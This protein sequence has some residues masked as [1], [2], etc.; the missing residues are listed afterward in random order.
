MYL[1]SRNLGGF[2]RPGG[3][4]DSSTSVAVD[5]EALSAMSFSSS[6][7]ATVNIRV[8]NTISQEACPVFV[9]VGLEVCA[10]TEGGLRTVLLL[11]GAGD[12]RGLD[13]R[14]GILLPDLIM[15]IFVPDFALLAPNMHSRRSKSFDSVSLKEDGG[16]LYC[17][18]DIVE[19]RL[20]VLNVPVGPL[21]EDVVISGCD[22]KYDLDDAALDAV[23]SCLIEGAAFG[24][25]RELAFS[26]RPLEMLVSN[27]MVGR[28]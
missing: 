3:S 16:R 9:E 2:D 24:D 19:P 4:P 23:L 6:G 28:S 18:P 14:I 1:L 20:L 7:G 5:F 21:T 12:A 15:W 27:N 17:P 13:G 10:R 22:P 26:P 8:I 11:K 25:L